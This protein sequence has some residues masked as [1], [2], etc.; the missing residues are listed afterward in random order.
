M[1]E[2]TPH[3][4]IWKRKLDWS[5]HYC[6]LYQQHQHW[7]SPS[8]GEGSDVLLSYKQGRQTAWQIVVMLVL[9]KFYRFYWISFSSLSTSRKVKLRSSFLKFV[10]QCRNPF[11]IP[12]YEK[13][14]LTGQCI[15]VYLINSI[16]I[17]DLHPWGEGSD[18][19]LS[20]M[21]SRQTP[22]K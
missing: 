14:K 10:L 15:I 16:S 3:T 20:Y 19:L 6:L 7:W 18:V 8:M 13:R 5:M 2:S 21:Q 4:F 12:S 1:W 17:D 11:P 9:V 22:G